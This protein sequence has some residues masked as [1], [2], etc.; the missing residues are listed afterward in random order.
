GPP[1]GRGQA[2]T[3]VAAGTGWQTFKYLRHPGEGR[4]PRTR[5]SV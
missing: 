1:R 5:L 3:T 2:C 4:D